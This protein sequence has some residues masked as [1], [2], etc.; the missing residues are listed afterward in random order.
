M[1]F[2]LLLRPA[3]VADLR[4][5]Y[6][7]YEERQP[8]LGA[9]FIDAVERKLDQLELNPWQF[10]AVRD[11]TRRA[12]VMRFPYGIFYVPRDELVTVLAVM[13]YAREPLRWRRRI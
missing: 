11:V 5:A 9:E 6:A 8:G 3:A 1:T 12:V 7:W 10:P 2:R 4:D 13:H